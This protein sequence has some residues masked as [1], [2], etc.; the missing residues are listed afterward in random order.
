[1]AKKK[2]P[3]PQKETCKDSCSCKTKKGCGC[4]ATGGCI[5]GLGFI[6][7]L[8]YYISTAPGF[9]MGA[10]GIIKAFL[11]PAFLVYELLAFLGM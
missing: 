5:Y 1:M 9:W 2:S 4:G 6:G 11:W 8:V 7:A 3:S 10:W